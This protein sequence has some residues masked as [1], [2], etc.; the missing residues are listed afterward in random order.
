MRRIEAVRAY[1]EG[2]IYGDDGYVATLEARLML[3]G[4]RE[5]G[6]AAGIDTFVQ[7]APPSRVSC[8]TPSSVETQI[9]FAT[10]GDGATHK[11]V[12]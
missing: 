10:T 4:M 12:S 9:S 5:S 8:T 2:E 6:S 7:C 1:A 3:K 11:I